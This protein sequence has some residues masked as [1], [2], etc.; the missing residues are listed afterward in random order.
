MLGKQVCGGSVLSAEQCVQGPHE[1]KS[2]CYGSA[3]CCICRHHILN[4]TA[5]DVAAVF[6]TS[7]ESRRMTVHS[8]SVKMSFHLIDEIKQTTNNKQTIIITIIFLFS[9]KSGCSVN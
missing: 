5:V 7:D 9:A 6:A 4:R 1:A 3:E 8:L 2:R